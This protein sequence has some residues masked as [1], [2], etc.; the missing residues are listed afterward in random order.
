MD[1]YGYI[2]SGNVQ[3]DRDGS[4]PVVVGTAFPIGSSRQEILANGGSHHQPFMRRIR[5]QIRLGSA[6][7]FASQGSNPERC[8]LL[9]TEK[10][11][12]GP[13][14]WNGDESARSRGTR[15]RSSPRVEVLERKI[16]GA[17]YLISANP[18]MMAL[19]I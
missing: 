10:L 16:V 17:C 3:H 8:N 15:R 9:R 2:P 18:V 6:G 4:V 11:D 12:D 1:P 7:S 14:E 5:E 19:L 13:P